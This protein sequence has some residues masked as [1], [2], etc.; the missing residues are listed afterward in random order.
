MAMTHNPNS[1]PD[2]PEDILHDFAVKESLTEMNLADKLKR[3][4]ITA[5]EYDDRLVQGYRENLTKALTQLS[6]HYTN[7]FL[8]LV[9]Q[10]TRKHIMGNEHC[11]CFT[12]LR[13]AVKEL[14]KGEAKD[15]NRS[16][17]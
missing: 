9:R 15:A 4:V 8:K 2:S 14:N 5:D 16:H 10:H 1:Q 12:E 17:S 13:T 6:E 7:K 11:A 3:R